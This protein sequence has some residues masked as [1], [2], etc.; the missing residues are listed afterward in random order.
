[1]KLPAWTSPGRIRHSLFKKYFITLFVAVVMPLLLGAL[2]DSWFS[3]RDQR[4][5]LTD[6]LRV[7][8]RSAAGRIQSFMEDVVQQLG[9]NVQLSWS[10]GQQEQHMLDA[11]RVLRQMPAIVSITLVDGAGVERAFVSRLGLNRVDGGSD[12]TNDPAVRGARRDRIWFGPVQYQLGSEPHMIVAISGNRP[13]A[14][15]AIADVNLKLIWDLIAAIKVGHSGDAFVIDDRGQLIAHRDIGL[16]LGG[17]ASAQAFNKM[18]LDIVAA[19]GSASVVVNPKTRSVVAISTAIASPNWTVIT[20]VPI[21]EAFASIYAALWRSLGL[22]VVGVGLAAGLA[23][24]LAHHMS[25]PIRQ[26]EDGVQRIGAGQFDHR[27]AITSGDELEQLADHFNQ[28]VGELAAS[29]EKTERINRL[30]RFLAPQVAELVE[31]SGD[32]SLLDGQRREVV[33]LF[34]DLRGFT[35]F[36]AQSEPD[37][38]MKVLDEYYQAL[39]SII[40]RYAATPTSFAGDGLMVLVNAPVPCDQPA[41][42]GLHLAIDMQA[43]VQ[44]LIVGWRRRGHAIGFGI[45]VAMG[46]ATV[47]KI[48]YEGRLDYTAIGS[49]VNLAS[50]LCGSAIDGQIL[51][52]PVAAAAAANE[53]ALSEL[54][55]ITVRGY[56]RALQVFAV[57]SS[58]D[59]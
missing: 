36:S 29:R 57:A 50:R 21:G 34:A 54:G 55:E 43:S 48:G 20:E 35:G 13:A 9:W 31:N 33:V 26:L 41:V 8:S 5:H 11:I 23:Y 19:G 46:T 39:G 25:R 18:R 37:V 27:I 22:L 14:G 44:R 40:T 38:V 45:G 28:M 42:Q 59:H 2:S 24:W 1:M 51:V 32:E 6:L 53:I 3:Y 49:A 7:E 17:G 52:D 58:K 12:M 47:G 56:D 10:D 4:A 15:V 30:K 16:V